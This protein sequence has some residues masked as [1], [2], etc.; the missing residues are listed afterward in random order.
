MVLL[1]LLQGLAVGLRRGAVSDIDTA[2][3]K[4]HYRL[5]SAMLFMFC[6][7]ITTKGLV[8]DPIK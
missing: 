5:T 4:L 3:F 1:D 8:G 6:L 7:L 2:I